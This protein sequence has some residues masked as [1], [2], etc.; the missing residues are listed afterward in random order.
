MEPRIEF[1]LIPFIDRQSS[2]FQVRE[3]VFK[4]MMQQIGTFKSAHEIYFALEEGL[5]NAIGK[6]IEQ[7]RDA[8]DNDKLYFNIA[9]SKYNFGSWNLTV[10]RWKED[11][12]KEGF[13]SMFDALF[14]FDDSLTISITRVRLPN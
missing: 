9:S 1:N 10:K 13:R 7:D 11:P 5:R 12:V 3:R 6:V 8:Q 4:T 2:R 14:E